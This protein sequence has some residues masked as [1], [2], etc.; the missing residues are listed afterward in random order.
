MPEYIH[1]HENWTNFTWQ[2]AAVS[3]ILG[4]VRLK[5]G[6]IL[7]QIFSLGFSSKEEK[8]LEILTTDVLKS[9]EI[10]GEK[11]D[12]EQVRSSVARRLGIETA[13]LVPSPRNV[14][15]VVE[16]TLDATQNYQRPLTEERLLGW[17]AALFPTGYSGIGKISVGKYRTE[18]VQVVSGAMGKEKVH[19][20]AVAAKDVAME[21][22]RFLSWFN[23][24]KI[25]MDDVLRS[26]IAHFWFVTIH[27]FDDGNG[28]ITR[29]I[30][31][32]LLA[33]SERS[34]ERFYSM[35][36]QIL[37]QR[38]DYYEAL[39]KAQHG[40]SDITEWIVWYMG[41]LKKALEETEDTIQNV[42]MKTSFWEKHKDIGINERQRK[43]INLLLDGF[44]EKLTSSK[45]AKMTKCSDDTALRDIDDLIIKG[46]LCKSE[47]GGRSTNYTLII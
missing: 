22:D 2:N 21:M 31:D 3:A 25:A 40:G 4:E 41:T 34:S 45:W 9:S 12:Y 11:L 8:N 47:A 44:Q 26:A 18:E 32:M 39:K 13:G 46:I 6:M 43:M 7:G 19:Y 20:E 35:S 1:Q 23:D 33:R 16:M 17:H 5:Q 15:G 24:E 37:A 42:L 29:A 10:E 36:K 38:N 28:R 27:P 30:S 14:E